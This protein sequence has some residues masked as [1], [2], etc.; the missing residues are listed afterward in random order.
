M[1]TPILAGTLATILTFLAGCATDTPVPGSIESATATTTSSDCARGALDAERSFIL[2]A[3]GADT[4]LDAMQAMNQPV[5]PDLDIAAIAADYGI[6]VQAMTGI[7]AAT[8]SRIVGRVPER[9]SRAQQAQQTPVI[10]INGRNFR[11]VALSAEG[12]K[13]VTLYVEG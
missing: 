7:Q 9:R 13:P 10:T 1:K 2:C 12:K 4:A 8:F 3:S 5:N 11:K 6:G